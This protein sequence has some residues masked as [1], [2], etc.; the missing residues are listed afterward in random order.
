MRNQLELELEDLCNQLKKWREKRISRGIPTPESL[1]YKAAE[2][3]NKMSPS[4]V[5]K[6]TGLNGGRLKPARVELA[7]RKK[8]EQKITSECPKPDAPQ[9][10]FTEIVSLDSKKSSPPPESADK[11][12][13]IQIVSPTGMVMRM[14]G[15]SVD[16]A[17]LICSFISASMGELR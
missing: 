16:P 6:R 1:I 3:C 15:A 14:E 7:K 11:V 8:E 13:S 4:L 17:A 9:I 5:L 2:L 12:N 10:E